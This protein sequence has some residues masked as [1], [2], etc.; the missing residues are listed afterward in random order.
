MNFKS[1]FSTKREDERGVGSLLP[2]IQ[3]F[4]KKWLWVE[5]N[6]ILLYSLW[7]AVSRHILLGD[8][9]GSGWKEIEMSHARAALLVHRPK[10]IGFVFSS[11]FFH[12]KCIATSGNLVTTTNNS[13]QQQHIPFFFYLRY[14]KFFYRHHF[15]YILEIIHF[16]IKRSNP[17]LWMRDKRK[18]I[19]PIPYDSIIA[20]TACC[21]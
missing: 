6:A 3:L 8:V 4:T 11:F 13:K 7:K 10:N 5:C 16:K 2:M 15:P 12:K 14:N 17:Y 1:W 9:N 19:K 18:I 21:H 20:M